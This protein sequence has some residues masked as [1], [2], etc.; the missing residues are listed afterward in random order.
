MPLGRVGLNCHAAPQ[1]D[2]AI[3]TEAIKNTTSLHAFEDDL[4]WF[5]SGMAPLQ[6][7]VRPWSFPSLKA[8]RKRLMLH[9][10]ASLDH[11]SLGFVHSVAMNL[12][13]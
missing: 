5:W 13:Q 7:V 4:L 6:S 12:P 8:L 1:V 9:D 3:T 11:D 10:S 2:Q